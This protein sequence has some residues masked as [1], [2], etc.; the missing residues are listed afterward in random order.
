M[1][2]KLSNKTTQFFLLGNKFEHFT[3]EKIWIVTKHIKRCSTSLVI[4]EM[5]IK[6]RMAQIKA[7]IIP[8]AEGNVEQLEFIHCWWERK[9][10]GTATLEDR[11]LVSYNV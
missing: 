5:Q 7:P 2:I 4:R 9:M 3:K 1:I 11:A 8:S 6:A 10:V